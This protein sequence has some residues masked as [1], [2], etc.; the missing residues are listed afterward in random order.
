MDD[1][2]EQVAVRRHRGAFMFLYVLIWVFIV[3]FGLIALFS[4]QTIILPAESGFQFNWIGLVETVVFAGGAF[5]LW[6]RSDYCRIEYDYTFTNGVLD[7]GQVL[8]NKRRRYLTALEMKNVVRCG[9]AKGPGFQKTLNEQGLK[10]HNWFVNRDAPLYYFYFVKNNVKHMA[11]LE[12]TDEMIEM[13]RSKS[14]LQRGVWVDEKGNSS[15]GYG[16]S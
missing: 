7:V 12:L 15:Y 5:L 13:I 2:L 11:V 6:R 3:I 16:V 1:F 9:P 8:N 14:Y 10:K 4:L